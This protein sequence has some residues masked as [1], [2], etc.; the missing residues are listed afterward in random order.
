MP[1]IA[2]RPPQDDRE[3]HERVGYIAARLILADDPDLARIVAEF[4]DG[5]VIVKRPDEGDD[6]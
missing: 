1:S 3:L 5:L 4:L 6:V 2:P